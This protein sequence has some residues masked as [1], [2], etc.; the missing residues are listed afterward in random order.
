[1]GINGQGIPASD[2]ENISKNVILSLLF[3]LK[4]VIM[5]LF[6]SLVQT[7]KTWHLVKKRMVRIKASHL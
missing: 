7:I 4:K 3:L 6:M 5:K 2:F 1:M